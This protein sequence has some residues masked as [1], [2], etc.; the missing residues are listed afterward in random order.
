MVRT[1]DANI[2]R[3]SEGLRVIEDILRF[4]LN[5]KDISKKLKL[6]RHFIR[7]EFATQFY[8]MDLNIEKRDSLNDV[9]KEYSSS[10]INRKDIYDVLKANVYRVCEGLRVL[11]ELSKLDENL[12]PFISELKSIRYEIYEIEK[13]L[14]IKN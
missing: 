7:E 11:E 1:I 9:G 12:F 6:F 5:D 10:E 3:V 14:L 4:E 8:K 13:K 2:N